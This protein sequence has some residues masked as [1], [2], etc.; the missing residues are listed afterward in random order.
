M[1]RRTSLSKKQARSEWERHSCVPGRVER[2]NDRKAELQ[3]VRHIA[4]VTQA[5][6]ILGDGRIVA[7]LVDDESRL[8]VTRTAVVWLSANNWRAAPAGSIYG[9]TEFVFDW[10]DIIAEYPH[11]YWVEEMPRYKPPAYRFL[12]AREEVSGDI[13]V[14]YDPVVDQG[15]LI[16]EDGTWFYNG[17]HTSEFMILDD[18]H[19][20]RCENIGFV[21]HRKC[22]TYGNQ[23]PDIGLPEEHVRLLVLAYVFAS[24]THAGDGALTARDSTKM[25][26]IDRFIERFCEEAGD[27]SGSSTERK[28]GSKSLRAAVRAVLAL[29]SYRDFESAERVVGLIPDKEALHST[30][31]AVVADHLAANVTGRRR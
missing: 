30:L 15:P 31:C 16:C 11:I 19:L 22:R 3:T 7:S 21:R 25:N 5:H 6:R 20:A 26:A 24:R 28:R 4:H 23:C 29:W 13:G 9:G 27:W 1:A 8:K 17:E 10:S 2:F 12:L 18:L 14:R